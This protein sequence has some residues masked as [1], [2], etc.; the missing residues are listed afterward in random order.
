MTHPD[1]LKGFT[2]IVRTFEPLSQRLT[3][4]TEQVRISGFPP[5]RV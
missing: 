2:L 3:E 4:V 1:P 5:R